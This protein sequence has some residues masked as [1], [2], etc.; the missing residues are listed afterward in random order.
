MFGIT[1]GHLTSDEVHNHNCHAFLSHINTRAVQTSHDMDIRA[2]VKLCDQAKKGYDPNIAWGNVYSEILRKLEERL[3]STPNPM[4][5]RLNQA[6]FDDFFCSFFI[7]DNGILEASYARIADIALAKT[8]SSQKVAETIKSMFPDNSIRKNKYTPALIESWWIRGTSFFRPSFKPSLKT[9]LATVRHYLYTHDKLPIELRLGT[10][11]QNH[12]NK[13]RIS[14]LF[15][16]FLL[17]QRRQS[18]GESIIT[19]L[20]INKLGRDP[21]ARDYVQRSFEKN[22]TQVLE[23]LELTHSNMALITLPADKG[24]IQQRHLTEHQATL[25]MTEV[26]NQLIG[27]AT[28][29]PDLGI[30]IQD[31]YI[32]DRVRRLIFGTNKLGMLDKDKQKAKLHECFTQSLKRMNIETNEKISPAQRQALWIDFINYELPTL[33]LDK[34]KPNYFNFSCKDGIDRAGAASAYFNLIS[35][36]KA[37][38]MMDRTAFEQALHAAPFMVKGRGMN[39][40]LNV[41][42][43]AVDNLLGDCSDDRLWGWLLY[44]R[45]ENCPVN[46]AA[47]LVKKLSS[48]YQE[49]LKTKEPSDLILKGQKL[50]TMI[51]LKSQTINLS[52]LDHYKNRYYALMLDGLISC[53]DLCTKTYDQEILNKKIDHFYELTKTIKASDKALSQDMNEFITLL[54][55]A[56]PKNEGRSCFNFKSFWPW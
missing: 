49:L 14:P 17:A 13:P 15:E 46:C 40:H 54:R 28:G 56:S 21:I 47:A 10:Q 29:K 42:W 20:Y 50:L 1:E 12:Q 6:D 2:I 16:R 52:E 33:I 53:Y 23:D 44:W 45:I 36:I 55:P 9:S 41:I 25:N 4:E 48:P 18:S 35:S 19:H 24:L 5:N 38:Q 22:L 8:A 51:K 31:F 26:E 7:N 39:K 32:S 3:A 37:G 30:A 34:L 43:N 27:I 11:A